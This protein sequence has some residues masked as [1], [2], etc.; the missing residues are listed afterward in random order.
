MR[1]A[2][3]RHSRPALWVL[4]L[5]RLPPL[6]SWAR[7]NGSILLVAIHLVYIGPVFC[8]VAPIAHVLVGLSAIHFEMVC[9]MRPIVLGVLVAAILIAILVYAVL[10]GIDLHGHI[11]PSVPNMRALTATGTTTLA[12]RLYATSFDVLGH[13]LTSPN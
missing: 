13:V 11:V 5:F 9:V 1:L 10:D 4:S 12:I 6:L 7:S 8:V 3:G 2:R